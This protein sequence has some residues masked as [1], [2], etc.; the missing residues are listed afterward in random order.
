MASVNVSLPFH[1]MQ[2]E[3][4]IEHTNCKCHVFE[5]MVNL[6]NIL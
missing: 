2:E 5:H 6:L 3:D 4:S 1:S